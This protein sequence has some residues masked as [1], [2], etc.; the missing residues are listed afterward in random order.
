MER[1]P[2]DGDEILLPCA[3][4]LRDDRKHGCP[5][6]VTLA[7]RAQHNKIRRRDRHSYGG[8]CETQKAAS[9]RRTPRP[10]WLGDQQS[11]GVLFSDGEELEG[12]LAGGGA[13]PAPNCA[14]RWR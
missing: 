8:R 13:C 9:S 10:G 12:G 6:R 5:R 2:W 7:G 14:R 3:P 11:F 4:G 1:P